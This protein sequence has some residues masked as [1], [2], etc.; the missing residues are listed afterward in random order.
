MSGSNPESTT[1]PF[2][3]HPEPT[4]SR[5]S[6]L[7]SMD[8][9]S[10][11]ENDPSSSASS[12]SRFRGRGQTRSLN[13]EVSLCQAWVHISENPAIGTG[14]NRTG[15]WK[16]VH[17][18]WRSIVDNRS[19]VRSIESLEA[20][21]K[22][23]Q[24]EVSKFIGFV[25]AA[26]GRSG[27]NGADEI[28]AARQLFR[29]STAA[30]GKPG[31]EF[32]FMHCYEYL[33]ECQK[34]ST[35]YIQKTQPAVVESVADEVRPMGNKKAKAK[36]AEEHANKRKADELLEVQQELS[37]IA[38][39]KLEV[40]QE[41]CELEIM[42]KDTSTMNPIA[43]QYFMMRQQQILDVYMKKQI[44]SQSVSNGDGDAGFDTQ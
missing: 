7:M 43:K 26:K 5:S 22:V 18:H 29:E 23:I 19:P 33:K 31:K 40:A 38:R 42:S 4:L 3:S 44:Q 24:Y 2:A 8:S 14:Q 25:E 16:S 12:R 21:W 11:A 30:A 13:E 10:P 35:R 41:A 27:C 17:D 36:Q 37:K 20:R 6:S 28:N 34:F 1:Y 32:Q 39:Q 15:F 9:P